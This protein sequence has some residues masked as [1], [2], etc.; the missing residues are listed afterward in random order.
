[1]SSPL[2]RELLDSIID[3]FDDSYDYYYSDYVLSEISEAVQKLMYDDHGCEIVKKKL[4][5]ITES[6]L[7]CD[8]VNS[9]YKSN[10]IKL[11]IHCEVFIAKLTWI[12]STKKWKLTKTI[13]D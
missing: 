4:V 5:S 8:I 10:S 2:T 13:L 6:E 7:I 3:S 12:D 1:M 11:N 9:Y